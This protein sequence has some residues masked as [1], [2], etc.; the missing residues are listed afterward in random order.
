M[1]IRAQATKS[2]CLECRSAKKKCDQ[3]FPKCSLCIKKNKNCQY[4]A[5]TNRKPATLKYTKSLVDRIQVLEQLLESYKTQNFHHQMRS[6]ESSP[7][8]YLNLSNHNFID[9][10]EDEPYPSRLEQTT[11]EEAFLSPAEKSKNSISLYDPEAAMISIGTSLA[12]TWELGFAQNGT[13]LFEGPTS[14]RYISIF[15]IFDQPKPKLQYSGNALD[16]F[17]DEVFNWFFDCVSLSLPLIN[18]TLFMNSINDIAGGGELGK[19]ASVSLINAIVAMFFLNHGDLEQCRV[20]K[21]LAF[22]QVNEEVLNDPKIVAIQTLILLS[23]INMTEGNEFQSSDAIARAVSSSYHLGLHVGNYK[24]RAQGKI[25]QEEG[26]IRDSVFWCCFMVDKLRASIL[27][28]N[29]YMNCNDISVRLPAVHL[30]HP[31]KIDVDLFRD[32]ITYSD[33]QVKMLGSCFSLELISSLNEKALESNLLEQ[34]LTVSQAVVALSSWRKDMSSTSRYTNNK[35]LGPL[36]LETLQQTYKIL[37]YKPL[38]KAPAQT[39]CSENK[40]DPL[41]ICCL[42]AE[43]TIRLCES[44]DLSKGLFLYHFLYCLYI[45]SIICLYNISSPDTETKDYYGEYLNRAIFIFE[46]FKSAAPVSDT[47]LCHLEKFR[48][49]WFIKIPSCLFGAEDHDQVSNFN[50]T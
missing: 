16:S 11:E 34:Q 8:Y 40:D 38:I 4:V 41:L 24:L 39:R 47:Y 27:G 5:T 14:S 17:H 48:K 43:E 36:F 26:E 19:Y 46:K 25:S 23:I 50:V 21:S 44:Q 20:F 32:T 33:I 10:V 31:E 1:S 18:K 7:N 9:I 49:K 22:N 2:A 30:S 28:M 37:I 42:A 3:Q 29:P 45:A 12:S 35:S 15:D 13:L 6:P